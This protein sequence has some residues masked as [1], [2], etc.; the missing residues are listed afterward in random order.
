ME[1]RVIPNLLQKKKD[2]YKASK[3]FLKQTNQ[4]MQRN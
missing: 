1:M 4:N 3:N 2:L